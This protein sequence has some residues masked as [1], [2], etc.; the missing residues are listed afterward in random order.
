LKIQ[1]RHIF[2]ICQNP[3]ATVKSMW[4]ESGWDIP[5]RRSLHGAILDEWN[6]LHEV[7]QDVS[8]DGLGDDE[9]SWVLEKSRNFST[10][11]LYIVLLMGES[12]T[13]Y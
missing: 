11:S 12:K 2:E 8:L 13:S 6:D 1:Y 9:V 7:L 4:N 5:H 10:K 3:E